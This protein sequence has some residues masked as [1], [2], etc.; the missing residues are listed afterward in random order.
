MLLLAASQ[1]SPLI[2]TAVYM[3]GILGGYLLL[4]RP[5]EWQRAWE[6]IRDTWSRPSRD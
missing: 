1:P 3:I 2:Q 4:V 5:D 6:A